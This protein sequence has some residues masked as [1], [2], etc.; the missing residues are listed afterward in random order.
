M[1]RST[2]FTWQQVRDRILGGVRPV[3]S[4]DGITVTGGVLNAVSA[5]G[6]CNTNGIDDAVDISSGISNDCD[7]NGTP[8]E[9][10]PDCNENGTADS[11]D[12]A[13]GGSD[14]CD[15]G[16]RPDECEPDC[17]TNGIAD[18]CDITDATS[19]DCNFNGVPDECEPGGDQDCN[20]NGNADLCDLIQG[21]SNDC[22]QNDLPDECDVSIGGS[23][24]CNANLVPDECEVALRILMS[25]DASAAFVESVK[26]LGH[27]VTR[28]TPGAF[29]QD[30]SAY[31]VV[32]LTPGGVPG[33]QYLYAVIDDF[34][35]DGGGLIRIQDPPG[36]A[37]PFLGSA[38]P[39][40]DAVGW[41]LRT[42]TQVIDPAGPLAIGLPAS[43]TLSG[44]SAIYTLKPDAR[45]AIAWDDGQPM[46]VTYDYKGGKVVYF[47]DLW[48]AY[49]NLW[50]GDTP[51]GLVL[52][53]NAIKFAVTPALD[54]NRNGV[55][56]DCDIDSGA[57]EDC[58]DNGIPDECEPD[59]NDNSAAD[60]CDILAGTSDDEDGNGV[61]DECRNLIYVDRNATGENNGQSWSDAFNDLQDAIA[62]AA[63]SAGPDVDTQIW[64]AD[65]VY[66]PSQ[67]TDP[68]DPRSATFQL[69]DYVTV[70]GGFDGGEPAFGE[71][72]FRS[73][74]VV[75]SGDL[76]GDDGPGF[77]N[78]AENAYHVV[79]ASGSGSSAVLDGVTITAGHAY[80][81]GQFDWR[82]RGGGVLSHGGEAMFANCSI[83]ANR[84][85][86]GA[87]VY[88]SA[89]D[90]IAINCA[91]LGNRAGR[92]GGGVFSGGPN[93]QVVNSIF[94]GNTAGDDPGY[95]G[96][97]GGVAA[98]GSGQS[99]TVTNSAFVGNQVVDGTGGGIW[100]ASLMTT[101]VTNSVLWD[102]RR[103]ATTDYA[104]QLDDDS[105]AVTVVNYNAIQ[106]WHP[107]LGGSGNT[108]GSPDFVDADG[109]DD[110]YGTGD[111]NLR[112]GFGSACIDTGDNDAV[113]TDVVDLD[114]NN[115]SDEPLPIDLD[116]NPRVVSTAVDMGPYEFV[117]PVCGNDVV[118]AGEECDGSSDATCPEKCRGDCTCPPPVC[119]DDVATGNE[120]CDGADDG[121]CPGECLE[122]CTCPLPPC[123][124]NQDCDDLD[125][126]TFD[127]CTV[128]GCTTAPNAYGD[129]DFNG[130]VNLFDI[131][132]ILDGVAGAYS[133]NCTESRLDIAPCSGNGVVNLLDVFA[134]LDAL[135]GLDPCCT[136][137]RSP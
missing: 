48:A 110:A 14:D 122:D 25:G 77:S 71:R 90:L 130:F 10:E 55:P 50:E 29:P 36:Y 8:D 40:N 106:Y 12:I 97:G 78:T 79:T 84:A 103:D 11:C 30:L 28:V 27:I 2:E 56:D 64:I 15:G 45:T 136:G 53:E 68:S 100:S 21:L 89:G 58:S 131:F 39:L 19:G 116:G 107:G 99:A 61:P 102:N 111:E 76:N 57:S 81:G 87:G 67:R 92:Q 124:D 94:I 42:D 113:P 24:D 46:T 49:P 129:V 83:V 109:P 127:E 126:C 91:F 118:E 123:L 121:A 41:E 31:D 115:N 32:M 82:S 86:D 33:I 70:Y 66:T 85:L 44:Y 96:A 62:A 47:N 128:D 105:L 73:N 38:S 134:A 125:I 80:E 9:C 54:C 95:G 75:L 104:A 112:L 59:C 114:H 98:K 117:D 74:I 4:L 135:V 6:D 22:N 7:G 63:A 16:G 119:G 43:S 34:V 108:G 120:E 133:G 18:Q 93:L 23:Q 5:L 65:G 13:F 137:S 52:M 1:S 26:D 69:R 51:Y 37:L 17:N 20:V 60:S 132:C 3:A 35:A 101:T 72:D 88:S